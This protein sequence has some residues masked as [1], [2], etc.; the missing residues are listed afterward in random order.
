MDGLIWLSGSFSDGWHALDTNGGKCIRSR[1]DYLNIMNRDL[2]AL[3][4]ALLLGSL[5]QPYGHALTIL[6]LGQKIT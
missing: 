1:V 2:V 5:V 4:A 6:M 3:H